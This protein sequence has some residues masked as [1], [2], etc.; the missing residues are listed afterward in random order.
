MSDQKMNAGDQ[1]SQPD[2]GSDPSDQVTVDGQGSQRNRG[3][4]G[5]RPAGSGDMGTGD[6]SS[7]NNMTEQAHK[8]GQG[9]DKDS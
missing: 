9:G 3:G 2:S 8:S 5:A 4:Q 7:L 1:G 6:S